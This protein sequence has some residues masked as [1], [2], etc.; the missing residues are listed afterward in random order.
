MVLLLLLLP[1]RVD[2]TKAHGVW[3]G[4]TPEGKLRLAHLRHDLL[5]RLQAPHH[6][7]EFRVCAPR[8]SLGHA[9]LPVDRRPKLE[10]VEQH[11]RVLLKPPKRLVEFDRSPGQ[12]RCAVAFGLE[13]LSFYFKLCGRQQRLSNLLAAAATKNRRARRWRV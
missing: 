11:G 5:I 8:G 2:G 6:P 13:L 12:A 1:R 4:H 3:G 7:H 9:R 10:Q